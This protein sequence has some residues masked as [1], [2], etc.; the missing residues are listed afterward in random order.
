MAH[1]RASALLTFHSHPPLCSGLF[2]TSLFAPRRSKERRSNCKD[3][4]PKRRSQLRYN[5]IRNLHSPKRGAAA[6]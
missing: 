4:E 5:G 2:I 3:L 6:K 1:R